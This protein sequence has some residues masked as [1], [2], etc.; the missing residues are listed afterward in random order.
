MTK[1]SRPRR[2]A[3]VDRIGEKMLTII[4]FLS[5]LAVALGLTLSLER[6]PAAQAQV[7][8]EV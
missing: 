6:V 8:L 4:R 1:K 2:K 3:M 5:A 7:T